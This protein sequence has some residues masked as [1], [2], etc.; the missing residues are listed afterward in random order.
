MKAN[1][2]VVCAHRWVMVQF[3]NDRAVVAQIFCLKCG[4][5]NQDKI[6]WP[7]KKQK[8]KVSPNPLRRRNERRRDRT[9]T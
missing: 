5:V 2:S 1:L 3:Y 7:L 6:Q 8:A 9:S 4:E